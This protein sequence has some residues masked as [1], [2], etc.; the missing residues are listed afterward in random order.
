MQY[1]IR[2]EGK[3]RL[4]R[5]LRDTLGTSGTDLSVETRSTLVRTS[6]LDVSMKII[7]KERMRKRITYFGHDSVHVGHPGSS[8]M[9]STLRRSY[10][11]G[12]MTGDVQDYV[13][14]C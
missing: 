6:P 1:I 4:C 2:A 9:F 10:Y 5:M 7:V 8:C 12:N 14:K 13:E 3:N 11:W